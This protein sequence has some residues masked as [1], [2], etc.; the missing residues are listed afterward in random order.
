MYP[1]IGELLPK[2]TRS[3]LMVIFGF[4]IGLG[5]LLTAGVGF[6]LQTYM[7]SLPIIN[8]YIIT[9]W[10]IQMLVHL[11]PGGIALF[12]YCTLPESPK[13]LMSTGKVDKAL[14]VLEN[15]HQRNCNRKEVFPIKV[16]TEEHLGTDHSTS[17]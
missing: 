9:P 7:M 17:M 5:M 6:I 2:E 1:F 3:K 13:F 16:L 12:I 14:E 4:A 8:G 10:R 15:I 11:I